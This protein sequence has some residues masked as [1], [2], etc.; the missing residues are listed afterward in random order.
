MR[1]ILT[2]LGAACAAVI[3]VATFTIRTIEAPATEVEDRTVA[4]A[5]RRRGIAG[6]DQPLDDITLAI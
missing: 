6:R 1:K 4:P 2:T 3:L 5:A